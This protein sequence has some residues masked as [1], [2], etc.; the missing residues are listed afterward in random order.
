F[1]IQGNEN[2]VD[3][4]A[5]GRGQGH[6]EGN[7][8]AHAQGGVDLLGHAHEG[9]D[10][11]ELHQDELLG[12][13]SADENTQNG[14]HYLAASFFL[15]FISRC[16]ISHWEPAMT[17]PRVKK[18]PTGMISCMAGNWAGMMRMPSP[19]FSRPPP[20]VPLPSSSR[21]THM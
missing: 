10:A 1:K 20:K 12:Q 15:F 4:V 19:L 21:T 17:K 14:F 3:A 5:G 16:F 2:Q 8:H 7:G 6:D 18:P 11:V 9:A 13:Q